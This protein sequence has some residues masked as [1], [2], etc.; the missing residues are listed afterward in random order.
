MTHAE[1]KNAL[2]SRCPVIYERPPDGPI[3]FPEIS[4]VI[5]RRVTPAA[6]KYGYTSAGDGCEDAGIAVSV[7]LRSLGGHSVTVA[8]PKYIRREKE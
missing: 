5:Y 8:D 1:V 6:G 7:E 3:C 2:L 4:A